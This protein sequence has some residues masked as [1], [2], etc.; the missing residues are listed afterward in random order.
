MRAA[1]IFIALIGCAEEPP[2]GPRPVFDPASPSFWGTPWPS[3]DRTD[4]DGTLAVSTFPDPFGVPLL[5]DYLA[6]AEEQVGAGTNSPIYVL[7]QGPLDPLLLPTPQESL[8]DPSSTLI[9]VDID[10]DSAHWGER[11]PV[12]WEQ[13]AYDNSLY[14]PEHLLAVAP[15]H[16]YPLRPATRYALIVT[17]GAA[18]RHQA[19]A[20]RL[21]PDHPEH[22]P[23]LIRALFPLGLTTDDIAIA[24][25][26]TTLDPV[27]EMAT[28]ARYVQHQIAPANLD[29]Q[30]LEHLYDHVHYTAWRTRYFSPVFTHGEP[31]YLNEGGAFEFE[32]DGTPRMSRFDE[33][34]LAVC[35]PLGEA[36]A[37]GWPVVIYQ[38]GTGGSYRGFCNSSSA[39]EV[40]NRL[41]Q[42]GLLGVGIDQP[43][44][45]SRPGAEG[46]GDLAHFNIV[47]PD[48]GITNFRQGAIDAIYLARS[49]AARPHTFRA[50]DGQRFTTDP[51]RILFMGHSQ[52]GLTG[53]MAAP[54]VGND[55]KA[56]VLSG[57][58]AVLAIT[59]VERKDVLDFEQ[60]VRGLVDLQP[61]EPFTPLHPI[62]GVMQ[63]LVEPTDPGNY[64][65]FWFSQ[66]GPWA[67]HRPVPILL[68]SG[69]NDEATPYSTAIA[70]A[71]AARL[72]QVGEPATRAE[73]VRLR[74]GDPR[75]L[76][77]LL[78][79]TDFEGAPITSGFHQWWKGTHFVLFEEE[80]AS[81]L[82]VDFLRSAADG[83]I[84]LE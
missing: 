28:L 67:G 23:D 2:T 21:R 79:A 48:S 66:L 78:N 12:L 18:T 76:P 84:V 5:G 11:F 4:P 17:T 82:Y 77:Q 9:L 41:G 74:T 53:A 22:D 63:T 55:L 70:L 10:P 13:N 33:M 68:T 39:L 43:L 36:P 27:A 20:E 31:P 29:A 51:D 54:F 83:M 72:P 64:A 45:G 58:G 59:I 69:T 80:E 65:P 7:M 24:T 50:P 38:H 16:G 49:L 25:T 42:V 56:M 61:E 81:D 37:S 60:L 30:P 44:H 3:D 40:M 32:D 35:T 52:G 8:E 75:P 71:A 19:W 46:A 57:A 1:L 73:A 62:L 6:R 26:F 34:R 15:M 14:M 47:N